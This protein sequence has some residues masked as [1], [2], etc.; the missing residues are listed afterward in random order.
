MGNRTAKF[1]P[2]LF[3]SVLFAGVFD[4]SPLSAMPQNAPTEKSAPSTVDDCQASPGST[5]PP[6][7]HWYYRT[8]RGSKCWFLSEKG[9]KLV[10]ST[11][12]ATTRKS[13]SPASSPV[14]EARAE[15]A[16]QSDAVPDVTTSSPTESGSPP[17]ESMAQAQP[18]APEATTASDTNTQPTPEPEQPAPDTTSSI[19]APPPPAGAAPATA[20]VPTEKPIASLQML[21]LVG[22]GALTLAGIIGSVICRFGGSRAQTPAKGGARRRINWELKAA[23][24]PPPW[25]QAAGRPYAKRPWP[26]DSDSAQLDE[27]EWAT[28]ANV[29]STAEA[30]TIH[31]E[32]AARSPRGATSVATEH[33]IKPVNARAAIA[34]ADD[35]AI[36]VEAVTA[37]LERLAKEGPKLSR[38][39]SATES[40]DFGQIRR[41]QSDVPS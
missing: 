32:S 20:G 26:F 15:L 4:G 35:D 11:T 34:V 29:M 36:D 19:T 39:T 28:M 21:L 23:N 38:F 17:A 8:E 10:Q 40:A 25:T 1:M 31:P 14:R 22:G 12:T 24:N 9:E 37:M 13:D 3:T 6:G 18:V 16:S 33:D 27:T 7:L 2:A 41:G 5:T 30:P